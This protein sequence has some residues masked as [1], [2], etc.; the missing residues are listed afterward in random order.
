MTIKMA[1][2]QNLVYS[3]SFSW[4]SQKASHPTI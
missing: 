2:L 3:P 4:L 1:N